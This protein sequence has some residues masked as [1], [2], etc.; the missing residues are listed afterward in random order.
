MKLIPI[1]IILLLIPLVYSEFMY[2]KTINGLDKNG[3]G[4]ELFD[5]PVS[6]WVDKEY[7]YISDEGEQTVFILKHNEE[8]QKKIDSSG[9][10]GVYNPKGI[11]VFEGKVYICDD[12][13]IKIYDKKPKLSIFSKTKSFYSDPYAITFLEDKYFITDTSSSRIYIHEKDESYERTHINKGRFSGEIDSPYDIFTGPDGYLYLADAGNDRIQVFDSNLS[14]VRAIGKGKGAIFLKNPKGVFVDENFVFVADTD[15]D[16]IVVFDLLGTPLEVLAP[17]ENDED[18]DEDERQFSYPSDVFYFNGK[19][20]IADTG[21]SRIEVYDFDLELPKNINFEML[22]SANESLNQIIEIIQKAKVLGIDLETNLGIHYKQAESYYLE[23]KY[24]E[25][26]EELKLFNINYDKEIE[27]MDKILKNELLDVFNELEIEVIYYSSQYNLSETK[28]YLYKFEYAY[29]EE[30][31]L[32]ALEYLYEVKLI[33][34]EFEE[35]DEL[36][37]GYSEELE[38]R[39]DD[40]NSNL[41]NLEYELLVY[42]QDISL[43]SLNQKL[44]VAQSYFEVGDLENTEKALDSF[45]FEF[46][47]ISNSF[48]EKKDLIDQALGKIYEAEELGNLFLNTDIERAKTIVYEDPEEAKKIAERI[49]EGASPLSMQIGFLIIIVVIILVLFLSH[50]V[51]KKTKR[52]R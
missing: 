5:N 10:G 13:S 19:V 39:L 48:K 11:F 49:L 8:V 14:F 45:D 6:L 41:S 4:D 40:S 33:I 20:Y 31:Y 32:E 27:G 52:G 44:Q 7:I 29:Q 12:N 25:S 46:D 24:N 22:S 15:N 1:I 16:R 37:L 17:E 3:E 2:Y 26:Q 43:T 36:S 23:S 38:K 42:K 35:P 50:K 9:T 21:N 34:S 28:Q 51:V 47:I 30:I 18:E